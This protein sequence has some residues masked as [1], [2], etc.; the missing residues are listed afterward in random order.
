MAQRSVG[1]LGV[2]LV[3]LRLGL[4]SFGG[5]VA[6]IGFFRHAFVDAHNWIEDREFADLLALCQFIPGPA[7]SQ[8]GMAIGYH[9]AGYSGALAA[10]LGF[11][12]PSAIVLVLFA[13]AVQSS[14]AIVESGAVSGLKLVA[15][16][17]VIHA[18]MGMRTSL[19]PDITRVLVMLASCLL[20]ILWQ[21]HFAPIVV[22]TFTG[23]ASAYIWKCRRATNEGSELVARDCLGG[24]VIQSGSRSLLPIGFLLL[25]FLGLALPF[26]IPSLGT[27]FDQIFAYYRSGAMVFGGGHVVLPLLQAEVVDTQWVDNAQFLAGYG[28]AQAVPGPLFTFASFLGASHSIGVT[29]VYGAILASVFVFLPSFFLLF[30]VLP[31][32]ATL[33]NVV[34]VKDALYAIN[35]AV[36]GLLLATI[37]DPILSY[38]VTSTVDVVFAA[39]SFLLLRFTKLSIVY[40][41]IA[42]ALLGALVL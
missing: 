25:F 26:V 42:G 28:A 40:V 11:T 30:G 22:L 17:V 15:V 5:P 39:A 9:K 32:W 33:K 1:F 27:W 31:Y 29:G 37:Y 18:F 6:H 19:A 8:L 13:F 35:A 21:S 7:S 14:T 20:F 41:V 12:L 16:G 2:F 38:S 24:S 23:V 34:L 3:F 4:T 36:L 10:W